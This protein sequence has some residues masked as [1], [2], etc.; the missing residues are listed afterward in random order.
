MSRW[1]AIVDEAIR[2][3]LIDESDR[4]RFTRP[5][6]PPR[7]APPP[8]ARR[9]D[10]VMPR[11]PLVRTVRPV[12]LED[13]IASI[14]SGATATLPPRPPHRSPSPSRPAPPQGWWSRLCDAVER[15][16]ERLRSQQA[17]GRP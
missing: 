4:E 8:A 17:G 5:E 16:S 11:T 13:A 1:L 10:T 14:G 9:L 12:R 6:P 15:H 2:L 7:T 3:R